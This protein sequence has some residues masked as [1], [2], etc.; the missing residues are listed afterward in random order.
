MPGSATLGVAL[1]YCTLGAFGNAVEL[2]A[3]GSVVRKELAEGRTAVE[4]T[5]NGGI[6]EL[7]ANGGALA[8]KAKANVI[9]SEQADPH[10][11]L[12]A[13]WDL[14]NVHSDANVLEKT[15]GNSEYDGV[16]RTQNGNVISMKVKPLQTDKAF[17]IGLSTTKEDN[18]DFGHGHFLSFQDQGRL[19]VK[20]W[21]TVNY[22]TSDEF[23]LVLANGKMSV[24]KNDAKV[25]TFP[26]DIA[27]TMWASVFMHDVGAKAKVTEMAVA[28]DLG[29]GGSSSTV[30]LANT[31]PNGPPGDMG[32]PGPQ[33]V[34]GP[35]G[36]PGPP[37]TVEMLS[38]PAPP[39]PPGAPG[40]QGR[41]GENG[42]KGRTGPQGKPGPAGPTTDVNPNDIKLW[43]KTVHELDEAIKKANEVDRKQQQRLNKRINQVNAHLQK[44]DT[45][46]LI[47]ENLEEKAFVEAERQQQAVAKAT[48]EAK[49]EER[50]YF[51]IG[52]LQASVETAATKVRNQMIAA[53]E[54]AAG[55]KGV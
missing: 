5:A 6:V 18:Q 45:Q 30:V 1:V 3:D 55:D 38:A 36:D 51:D 47:Q 29:V 9:D 39:G 53:V 44:V 32:P 13:H 14:V 2:R 40:P 34:V 19:E 41:S 25:H 24:Y 20:G 54:S 28:A 26:D 50:S 49:K 15:S 43:E 46:L 10:H 7:N 33:G 11:P 16:A 37:A 8:R 27:K 22:T 35:A 52:R 21:K 31:G 4:V 17:R 23:G 48:V 12:V 42:R